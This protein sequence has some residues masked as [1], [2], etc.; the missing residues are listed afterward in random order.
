MKRLLILLLFALPL[1]AQTPV[2]MS[3][4]TPISQPFFGTLAP[5]TDVPL[6][7]GCVF[8][9]ISGTSTPLATYVD[10]T[11]TTIN[12]N[13]VILSAGGFASIWLSNSTYRFKVV[14]Y[15]GS[16]DNCATGAVQ[17]TVDYVSAWTVVNQAS[18][19]FVT[20]ASSDPS[21]TAG[22]LGCRSDLS[23]KLRYYSTLWDSVV[24]ETDTATLTNKTLTA[25]TITTP[26][27]SGGNFTNP[28][29]NGVNAQT[30]VTYTFLA[31]DEQKLV[32]LN[33][34]AA[35]AVTLPVAS[36]TGFGA[37]TVF[38]VRNLGAGTVTVTPTTSNINGI[39]TLVLLTGQGAD[40]YS[41][42]ANYESQNG[43]APLAGGSALGCTNF[44]PATVANNNTQQNLLSCSIAAN[45][46]LQGS[47]L[48]VDITGLSSTASAQ[49]ITIGMSV[50]A[51]TPCTTTVS[52]GVANNQ[53]FNVIG[54]FAVLTTGA[55]GTANWSC[56]GF[57]SNGAAGGP[58][59]IG[60]PTIAVNTTI[61]NTLQ[62]TVQMSVANAGNSTT[63]Q[64]LKAV[65][66]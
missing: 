5:F 15:D 43:S 34:A 35:V 11:G 52:T 65:I 57:S 44:T 25:P 66:Y 40:I 8:T 59:V 53:V 9:Y 51:G 20:C 54:K 46:L 39:A 24:T 6:A 3:P 58:G 17:Y 42:G 36:T 31:T 22:E 30:G 41:D 33:N 63:E 28:V 49:S 32:T 7:S 21:G 60:T 62:I 16:N 18:N 37:G 50:G 19:L 48:N 27:V 26:S 2:A 13:P 14:A 47:L 64:L 56:E 23:N 38:H 10:G 45:A 55:T 61:A 1:A 12:T 29:V 4:L